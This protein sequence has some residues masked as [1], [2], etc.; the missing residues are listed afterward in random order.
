LAERFRVRGLCQN[1]SSSGRNSPVATGG[2]GNT[3]ARR[4]SDDQSPPGPKKWNDS[5]GPSSRRGSLDEGPPKRPRFREADDDILKPVVSM[6]EE[7]LLARK[8]KTSTSGDVEV[9]GQE[10]SQMSHSGAGSEADYEYGMVEGASGGPL[11]PSIM[12]IENFRKITL[13]IEAL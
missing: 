11:P 2:S 5:P 6:K 3:N 13:K 8:K 4:K 9:A 12:G 10:D 1:E 7:S